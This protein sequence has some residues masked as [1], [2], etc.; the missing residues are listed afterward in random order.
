MRDVFELVGRVAS[1]PTTVLLRGESGTG[2]ELVARALHEHSPSEHATVR[3]RQLRRVARSRSSRPSCSGTS[4]ARSP[5]RSSDGWDGSRRP[6][7]ARCFSTRSGDLPIPTQVKLLRVLQ[8]R[9]IERLG[10]LRPVEVDVRII[11]ATSR[12][13]EAM[14][15]DGTFREDLYYRLNVFTIGHALRCA[16]VSPTS[17]SSPTTS[18][19]STPRSLGKSGQAA[20]PR[21]R[22]TC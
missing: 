8:S 1:S 3:R 21:R 19:R 9:V 12:D 11:A 14:V 16:T 15:A 2:K 20:S 18:S 22:S 6:T 10:S 4:A 13:L 7:R 5:G 17:C